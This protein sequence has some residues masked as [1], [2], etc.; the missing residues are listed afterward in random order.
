MKTLLPITTKVNGDA[1]RPAHRLNAIDRAVTYFVPSYGVK[2][3]V[4]RNTLHQ[5]GYN[6]SPER[7]G[8]APRLRGSETWVLNRDR[9]KAMED[10]RDAV[11]YDWIGGVL[12]KVVLYVCGKL[13]CKSDTGDEELNQLYDDYFHDWCGDETRE[14]D[15]T[16]RCDLGGRH[17]FIKMVQMAFLAYLVDGD[18]GFIEIAP[19][20]DEYSG[21]ITQ[22]FA[23]QGIE[24]DRI[25]S[26]IDN[27]TQENYVGGVGINPESGRVEYYRIYHRTRTAMWTNPRDISV[28]D[29]IHVFDPDRSDEFRGRTKLMRL[30]ND[31]RDLRE[32]I[33]GEKIAIKTQAQ[34]AAMISQR[35]PFKN[36]GPG[37]WTGKT[38]SGTPTQDAM[39][40]K[41]LKMAEGESISMLAPAARPS[42]AF[43]Q[44][45]QTLIRKMAVSLN[46]PFGF[47][48]DLVTLG[49]VTARIEVQSAWRQIQYWQ[50]NVL[51]HRILNRVRQKVLAQGIASGTLPPAPNWKRCEWHFGPWI[52]TDAGYEMQNDIAGV[53][54]G[55]ATV[56]DVCAKYDLTPS[57][58][59][60]RNANTANIAIA[61]GGEMQLPVETFAR[62]LYP[63][64][65]MQ[66][67]AILTPT[68]IPPPAPGSIDAIGDKGVAKILDLLKQVGE[69]SID[70]KSGINTLITV[71][72][73]DEAT[74]KLVCPQE[75]EEPVAAAPAPAQVV[76]SKPTSKSKDKK[77]K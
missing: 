34:W 29:F 24:A 33:E 61:I 66:K 67:N 75:P 77:K 16:T 44:F 36:T 10:A 21:E 65:T 26:P 47:L 55:I 7:R 50:S 40:G 68:P 52:I 3:L 30:L 63:D 46:L 17:R 27:V 76:K 12:A 49:G 19:G 11:Q 73:M 39:W 71:F 62:G 43:L 32:T 5:F 28:A 53:Q 54:T 72:G 2:A 25:G 13:H 37:A 57:E 69:G 23:L 31:M 20:Y 8:R 15:S 6:D 1:D 56:D 48:W 45:W 74:A 59:F 58:V 14:E 60:R 4:A 70:R 35:D 18:Y 42:G 22:D 38:D 64:L 9:L 41:I 51:E